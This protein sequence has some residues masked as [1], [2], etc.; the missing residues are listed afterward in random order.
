[1][2]ENFYDTLRVSLG[3]LRFAVER[4]A[5]GEDA[6][7]GNENIDS[8]SAPNQFEYLVQLFK[9]ISVSPISPSIAFMEKELIP[10]PMPFAETPWNL[11]FSS[12]EQFAYKLNLET[13]VQ[14]NTIADVSTEIKKTEQTNTTEIEFTTKKVEAIRVNPDESVNSLNVYFPLQVKFVAEANTE[15]VLWQD[16]YNAELKRLRERQEA[17]EREIKTVGDE[18]DKIKQRLWYVGNDP[19]KAD[20]RKEL[21]EKKNDAE[22]KNRELS[23][24]K[25]EVISKIDKLPSSH[26]VITDNKEIQFEY[27]IYLTTDKNK[28]E[29][30]IM[31]TSN[32]LTNEKINITVHDESK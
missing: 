9:P 1:V 18:S 28:N 25:S 14:P 20:E 19:K 7:A 12:A 3:F 16:T 30:L 24:E 22:K 15:A 10:V 21:E 26:K 29:L 11:L 2:P 31:T 13:K 27:S 6:N 5:D 4:F 23:N 32:K 8:N 17:I